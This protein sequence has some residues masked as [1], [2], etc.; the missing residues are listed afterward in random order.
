TLSETTTLTIDHQ[1]DPLDA[2][3]FLLNDAGQVLVADDDSGPGT[4]SQ[5]TTTLAPGTYRLGVGDFG[6]G[7]FESE[8][9]FIAATPFVD[10][11]I[12][13]EVFD[14][15]TEQ[16]AFLVATDDGPFSDDEFGEYTLTFSEPVSGA[17]TGI[18]VN[19]A[20]LET[21][22][23]LDTFTDAG[24]GLVV[25]ISDLGGSEAGDPL[26]L[27]FTADA[28][29]DADE[30]TFDFLIDGKTVTEVIEI[31]PVANST[32]AVEVA[33]A[34]ADALDNRGYSVVN[35]DDGTVTINAG[36]G[37]FPVLLN[38]VTVLGAT[39]PDFETQVGLGATSD[40]GS[41]LSFDLR[42][43][44]MTD[45]TKLNLNGGSVILAPDTLGPDTTLSGDFGG[46]GT[47]TIAALEPGEVVE[48]TIEA[49]NLDVNGFTL[50]DAITVNGDLNL[51][52]SVDDTLIGNDDGFGETFN[53]G[54]GDDSVTGGGGDDTI[55]G[56]SGDDTLFG[57]DG[58]DLTDETDGDGESDDDS[59]E[60]GAGD[61]LIFG[62]QG[63]DV[64]EGGS[65]DDTIDGGDGESILE[66]GDGDDSLI[67]GPDFDSMLGGNGDDTL[68]GGDGGDELSGNFGNDVLEGGDGVD[69]VS[70][71]DGNDLV[72]G[73]D[74]DDSVLGGAGSDTMTGGDGDD[75]FFFSNDDAGPTEPNPDVITDFNGS[76][77][78]DPDDENDEIDLRALD[79]TGASSGTLFVSGESGPLTVETDL[80][81]FD[82]GFTDE[83]IFAVQDGDDVQVIVDLNGNGIFEQSDAVFILEDFDADD[84]VEGDFIL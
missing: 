16:I 66:G 40:Q 46:V 35:N 81:D 60:G 30:V 15:P 26:L 31:G 45:V 71:G 57:G 67:G 80:G 51:T 61:D 20:T 6:T 41:G 75:T 10:P 12:A 58:D 32:E 53:G 44:T 79:F 62:E 55:S 72:E 42:A 74:G 13:Q 73:G 59:I 76:G 38:D 50:A 48:N 84:L 22:V 52:E 64:I 23:L 28:E 39:E 70:G 2:V 18:T 29:D 36:P 83:V 4:N 54:S 21:N 82:G 19:E 47:I 25:N 3:L 69:F 11:F 34:V 77:E 49:A 56:G 1:S 27:A 78:T 14:P 68:E 43:A 9:D 5:I 7:A 24:D 17:D 37:G 65:G 63:F 33:T 8:A